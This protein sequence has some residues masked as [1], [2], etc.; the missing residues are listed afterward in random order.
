MYDTCK[1]VLM[2]FHVY[3]TQVCVCSLNTITHGGRVGL[4]RTGILQVRPAS[5]SVRFPIYR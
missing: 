5:M 2:M 1:C 4:L 3:F